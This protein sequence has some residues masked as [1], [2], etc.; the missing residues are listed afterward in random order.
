MN[1]SKKDI[2]HSQFSQSALNSYLTVD[3]HG[4]HFLL[5]KISHSIVSGYIIDTFQ[6]MTYRHMVGRLLTD[7]QQFANCYLNVSQHLVLNVR[8]TVDWLS[9]ICQPTSDQQYLLGTVLHF[10]WEPKTSKWN[11][12]S[13]LQV[14]VCPN[15]MLGPRGV[16]YVHETRQ[17]SDSIRFPNTKKG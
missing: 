12:T 8:K 16:F 4:S 5:L 3:R 7:G 17:S 2:L 13:Q 6:F 1:L 11:S 9:A 15:D 14:Y 10:Y